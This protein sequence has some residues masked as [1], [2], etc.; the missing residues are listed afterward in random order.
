MYS[1]SAVN[2]VTNRKMMY[3]VSLTHSLAVTP[4]VRKQHNNLLN[5]TIYFTM[6][7]N[8]TE[9]STQTPC[10]ILHRHRCR[11]AHLHHH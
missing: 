11:P 1:V 2:K 6:N 5:V 10:G 4:S 8:V 7:V 3:G 9:R